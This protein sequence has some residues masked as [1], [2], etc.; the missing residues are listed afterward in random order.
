MFQEHILLFRR[1]KFVNTYKHCKLYYVCLC[2]F[3]L[4]FFIACADEDTKAAEMEKVQYML[5]Q[6]NYEAFIEYAP[7]A[8]SAQRVA[9]LLGDNSYYFLALHYQNAQRDDIARSLLEKGI[10][11]SPAF[12]A[13]LCELQLLTLGTIDER[14]KRSQK[15]VNRYPQ[16]EKGM[17]ILASVLYEMGKYDEA[18][19]YVSVDTALYLQILAQG[20]KN[21]FDSAVIRWFAQ[22]VISKEQVLFV[23]NWEES[24]SSD[25][26]QSETYESISFMRAKLRVCVFQKKYSLAFQYAQ[27]LI[28]QDFA[29]IPLFVFSDIGKAYI[30]GSTDFA[31][32]AALFETF[33]NRDMQEES[34]F[35]IVFYTARLYEKA[36]MPDKALEYYRSAMNIASTDMYYDTALW[37][38]LTTLHKKSPIQSINALI[39]FAPTWHDSAYF[40]DFLDTIS[41]YFLT[42]RLWNDFYAL[43][44][45]LENTA[46]AGTLAKWNYISAR[47]L[48]ETYVSAADA[49]KTMH[50]LFQKSFEGDHSSLYY[51]FLSAA[52]LDIPVETIESAVLRRKQ[53]NAAIDTDFEMLLHGYADFGFPEKVYPA[54]AERIHDI[55]IQTAVDLTRKLQ[56]HGNTASSFAIRAY[57]QSLRLIASAV[58]QVDTPITREHL[59]LLY[60]RHFYPLVSKAAQR[61]GL[62]E[63]ILYGLIRS[64]SFFESDVI[65]S[66]GAIGLT[67]LMKPTAGDIARK[68]KITEYDLTDPETNITFGAFYIDELIGRLDNQSLLALFAY[69]GGITRVRNWRKAAPDLPLDLFLETIPFSETQEY[70]RK[71]LSAAALYGYLYYGKTP[72]EV[73]KELFE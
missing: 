47:L 54:S 61:F 63:Y 13:R 46:D 40:S 29:D 67:Q 21:N 16:D 11:N 53:S 14:L 58:R 23:S 26:N 57:P 32:N 41:I 6:K 7:N 4:C 30:Y 56:S 12:L 19:Q 28:E 5:A 20:D 52:Q 43:N 44:T 55:S 24:L 50:I 25:E 38:Y 27:K 71:M 34:R 51:R 31:Q 1:D 48:Q 62:N 36:A 10:K 18:L 73:V 35:M 22:E 70:G 42:N 15:Y 33:L 45:I 37:Y 66:A 60:P 39:E 3:F 65:S 9:A 64:E 8:F 69:N 68:L 59:E 2:A 17:G 49:E 72:N